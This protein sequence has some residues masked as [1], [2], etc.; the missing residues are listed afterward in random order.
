MVFSVGVGTGMKKLVLFGYRAHRL[1]PL[2]VFLMNWLVMIVMLFR[3]H[4][5]I[6]GCI[7]FE[8]N[9]AENLE[10][11]EKKSSHRHQ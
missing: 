4:R 5:A 10:N 2:L 3:Y 8:K 7:Q 1:L 11:V 9:I 6:T